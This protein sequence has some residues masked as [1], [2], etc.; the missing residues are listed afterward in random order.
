MNQMKTNQDTSVP[1]PVDDEPTTKVDEAAVALLADPVRMVDVVLA[2][3]VLILDLINQVHDLHGRAERCEKL[4]LE[5]TQIAGKA[6]A[7]ARKAMG[8]R[9]C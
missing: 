9:P 6:L 4:A 8:D 2:Q 7:L 5:A 1:T 3:K